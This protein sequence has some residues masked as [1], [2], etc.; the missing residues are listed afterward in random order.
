M[1]VVNICEC[2]KEFLLFSFFVMMLFHS[3]RIEMKKGGTQCSCYQVY[4]IDM[5]APD[6][7]R[8]KE[9]SLSAL[10]KLNINDT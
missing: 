7:I 8:K 3:G 1:A 10:S 4:V 9:K 2:K 6:G 5:T